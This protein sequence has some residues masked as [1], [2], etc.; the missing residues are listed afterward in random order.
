VW[1]EGKEIWWIEIVVGV[2]NMGIGWCEDG[3]KP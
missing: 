1:I 3:G 2:R